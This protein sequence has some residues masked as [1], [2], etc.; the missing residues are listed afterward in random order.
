M[1]SVRN[2]I[3][4]SGTQQE[5]SVIESLRVARMPMVSQSLATLRPVA[6]RG[7]SNRAAAR[8]DVAPSG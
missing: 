1:S 3:A 8:G 6:P 2:T 7:T 4:E 5:S